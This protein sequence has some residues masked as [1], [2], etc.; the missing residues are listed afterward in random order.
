MDNREF[1]TEMLRRVMVHAPKAV[2]KKIEPDTGQYLGDMSASTIEC[3]MCGSHT[4]YTF[5]VWDANGKFVTSFDVADF[6]LPSILWGCPML[7]E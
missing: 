1:Q 7:E 2:Q 6:S 3:E 5:D 4:T